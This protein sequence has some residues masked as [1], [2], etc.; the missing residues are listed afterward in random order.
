VSTTDPLA[1]A[2]GKLGLSEYQVREL[3]RA[4]AER[5]AAYRNAMQA[6]V[7]E[8]E[9]GTP[10]VKDVVDEELIALADEVFGLRLKG[11]LSAE[12]EADWNSRGFAKTFAGTK[13]TP[14]VDTLGLHSGPLRIRFVQTGDKTNA[15][16]GEGRVG[17]LP[18]RLRPPASS[19]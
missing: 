19:R 16:D 2:A 18:F 15:G 11:A 9:D 5:D 13:P 12:Q 8:T 7:A 4:I 10:H 3:R 14:R 17:R 6:E 1:E